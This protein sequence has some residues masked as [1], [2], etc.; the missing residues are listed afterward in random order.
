MVNFKL[1]ILLERAPLRDEDK[2]N[3]S[4]IFSA[5]SLE[6]QSH[7]LDNWELYIAKIVQARAQIEERQAREFLAGL[8]TINT[9]LDE[10]IIREQEKEAY[11]ETKKREIRAELE[12]TVAYGQMQKLRRIKEVSK[13]PG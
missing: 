2:H 9:L 11:K 1:Q 13:N 7:I 8:K 4:V 3:I 10:A 6:R 12:S 5:L